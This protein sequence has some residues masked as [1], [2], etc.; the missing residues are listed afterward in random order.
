V[1]LHKCPYDGSEIS[2][3]AYSGGSFLLSCDHCGAVWEAH[4][5][6]VY[7]VEEPDWAVVQEARERLAAEEAAAHP[8]NA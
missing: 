7:R 1:N 6:L 4:N 2:A 5:S 8:S 3:E